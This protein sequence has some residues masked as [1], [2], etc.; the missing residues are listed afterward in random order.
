MTKQP[1]YNSLMFDVYIDKE[2]EDIYTKLI[3]TDFSSD[4]DYAEFA[5]EI[6]FVGDILLPFQFGPVSTED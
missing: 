4:S 5:T 2:N 1:E 3:Q 6:L